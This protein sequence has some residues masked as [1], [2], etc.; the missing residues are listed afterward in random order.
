VT[1]DDGRNMMGRKIGNVRISA[2]PFGG[3]TSGVRG[4][5]IK[6]E[7]DPLLGKLTG[8]LAMLDGHLFNCA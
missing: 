2:E 1:G 4:L 5:K 3:V 7:Y 6:S 8:L